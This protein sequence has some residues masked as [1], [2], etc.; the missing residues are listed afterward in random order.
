VTD[1]HH[2]QSTNNLSLEDI[3]KHL[4]EAREKAGLTKA[5]VSSQTKITLD[6]LNNLEEGRP[7]TIASVYAR[8]F[9]RTYSELIQLENADVVYAAYK[10]L[11]AHSEDDLDKP[12]TSK[13]LNNDFP[14]E[15]HSNT[16]T[17][18]IV[19]LSILVIG[20]GALYIS[21]TF[22]EKVYNLL[23]QSSKEKL[24]TFENNETPSQV[25]AQVEEQSTA[26]EQ[27]PAAEPP[28]YYGRLTLRAEKST[29]AQV[30]VDSEPIVHVLF[31]P[32][33]SQSFEG[34]NS[35]NIVVGDGQALRMEWNGQDRGYIGREGP[36]E[37]FFN[38]TQ[39]ET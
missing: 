29:W 26:A 18:V 9:L 19:I 21:P 31:E 8:G 11:T 6:Q 25:E 15:N 5:D 33:Q 3:G 20:M 4:R 30:G 22:R 10:Q 38:L 23:P 1:R 17:I 16:L 13:Y 7:P 32:G 35:V 37:V 28:T 34:S 2:H 36:V 39:P 12:L 27:Q 14:F 24:P